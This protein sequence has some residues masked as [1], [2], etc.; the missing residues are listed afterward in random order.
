MQA[1]LCHAFDGIEAL[2]FTDEAPKPAFNS[3]P[4]QAR[5]WGDVRIRVRAAGINF[6]DTLMIKGQYQ[7]KP[8][9]PF[10]PGLE[11]AGEVIE[12]ADHVSRV[13]AGDRV[14]AVVGHGG[15]AEEAIAPEM[16]VF[17]IPDTMDW[18]SA[19]GFPIV[20]GTSGDA[21]MRDNALKKGDVLLVHG[22][23]GGVGLTAVEVGKRMGA[24]VIATAGGPDKLAI[25][26]QHGADH[27][28]DYR[29]ED[30]RTRVK[31]LTDGRGADVIYD[32]VGGKVFDASLR[33]VA[34]GG[35]IIVS[36]FASGDVPQIPANIVMVKN[37]TISGY[38]LGGWRILDP[39]GVRAAMETLLNWYA[40]GDLNP[41][42]SHTFDLKDYAEA[43]ETLKARKSTGKIVLTVS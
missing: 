9:L 7:V 11:V 19:A 30:I 42:T 31:A 10:S 37:V 26:E 25:A 16:N 2:S 8:P 5:A 36:G 43:L 39:E 17:P 40:A 34:Q 33:A 1:V 35:R 12:V 29:E 41:H 27:L 22:A 14:M 24:T 28:I 4:E 6:A 18:V 38:H 32:P 3:S 13:K 23:A 21:L 15:Y 20:Y